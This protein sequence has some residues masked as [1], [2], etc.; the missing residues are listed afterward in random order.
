MAPGKKITS[1]HRSVFSRSGPR[2]LRR[3]RDWDRYFITMVLEPKA[4]FHRYPAHGG[5]SKQD[6]LEKHKVYN[7]F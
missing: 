6:E 3:N 4:M 5:R 2:L 7:G 1:T